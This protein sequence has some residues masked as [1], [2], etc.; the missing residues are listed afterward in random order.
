[1][2]WRTARVWTRLRRWSRAR[3]NMV[4][5]G[6]QVAMPRAMSSPMMTRWAALC[7]GRRRAWATSRKMV[8]AAVI[9]RT[10]QSRA[11]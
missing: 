1:M 8:A 9:E 3:V 10:D 4:R 2:I 6:R 11:A 5:P 7:R